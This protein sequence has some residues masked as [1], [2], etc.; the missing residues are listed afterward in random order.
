MWLASCRSVEHTLT[1]F[2]AYQWPGY[3]EFWGH[4]AIRDDTPAQNP[5]TIAR[6]ARNIGR[7]VE[8]FLRVSLLNRM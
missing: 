2:G 4:Y 3:L 8:L 1:I 7:T 6:F 5:I